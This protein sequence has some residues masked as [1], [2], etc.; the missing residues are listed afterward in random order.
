ME[1]IEA[2]GTSSRRAE[3]SRRF[4]PPSG[5]GVRVDTYGYEGYTTNPAFDP[6]LA[7]VIVHGAGLRARAWRAPRRAL[8]RVR[9]RR[10]S[11]RTSRSCMPCSTDPEVAGRTDTA[12]GSSRR[13]SPALVAAAANVEAARDRHAPAQP[14]TSATGCRIDR[15]RRNRRGAGADAGQDRQ[16]RREARRRGAARARRSPCSKR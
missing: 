15:A 13:I 4:V 2:D 16:H 12:R 10:V 9:D 8:E 7:K 1:K 6:L 14:R 3:R 5:P 11:R